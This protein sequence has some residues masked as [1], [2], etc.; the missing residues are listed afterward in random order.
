M[1]HA[2]HIVFLLLLFPAGISAQEYVFKVFTARDGLPTSET[3][4]VAKD[5]KGFLWIGTTSGLSRYDGYTFTNYRYADSNQ[6]ISQVNVIRPQGNKLWVGSDAGLFWI[7]NNRI[8]KVSRAGSLTQGINDILVEDNQLL[9]ATESGPAIIPLNIIDSQHASL[10]VEQYLLPQWNTGTKDS[11]IRTTVIAK[12]SDGAIYIGQERRLFR[13]YNNQL[14]QVNIPPNYNNIILS[15]FPVSHSKV[16]YDGALS[17]LTRIDNGQQSYLPFDSIYQPGNFFEGPGEWQSGTIGVYRFDTATEKISVFINTMDNGVIW[18]SK[19]LKDE[20]FAWLASHNGLLRI[21]PSP[22]KKHTFKTYRNVQEVYSFYELSDGTMLVGANRGKVY[23]KTTDSIRF[24]FEQNKTVVRFAEVFCMYEDERKWLW[25]G[26]GYQGIAVSR[27]GKLYNY[28]EETGLHDNSI[29]QF[30][31]TS[32]G[33]LYAVGDQGLSEIIVDNND[34]IRFKKYNYRPTISQYAKFF[35]AIEGP[36]HTIWIAGQEGLFF[37]KNDSLLPFRLNN[38]LLT[39]NAMTR[40]G[41]GDV[42]IAAAG[43]GVLQCQFTNNGLSIKERYTSNDGLHTSVI[44]ELLA[45][46]N[47]NIWMGSAAGLGVIQRSTGHILNFTHEDGFIPSGYYHMELYQDKQGT[48]WA[49]TTAGITSFNPD[50]LFTPG[51]K[52]VL[53]L[54]GEYGQ[55]EDTDSTGNEAILQNNMQLSWSQNNIQFTL[56]G[57]HFSDQENLDYF[58]RL[59][60]ADTSWFNARQTRNVNYSK[61]NS[62]RY[63]FRAKVLDNK[64]NWSDEAQ[65]S[66]TINAPFWKQLWFLILVLVAATVVAWYIQSLRIKRVREKEKQKLADSEKELQLVSLNRDLVSSQLT[67]LRA[68]M[69]PH[70]IFNALNSVQQYILSG[71]ADQANRYLSKFSRLQR[72]VLNY[73]DQEF[74]KL[75]KEIELLQLYLELEQLRLHENFDFTIALSEDMDSNEINIPPMI[76]QPFI[77]NAIWHGLMPRQGQRSI[78]IHFDLEE[79]LLQCLI[80]DNGIGRAAAAQL[81]QHNGTLPQHTPKGM[82]LVMQRLHILQQQHKQPFEA[83]VTDI[84]AGNDEVTGTQVKLTLFTGRL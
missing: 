59:D 30:L 24:Y 58:Y 23:T 60:G 67:A 72:M 18:P 33:K 14:Q 47:N 10:N 64:G 28:T 29:K 12:A 34:S 27:N 4:C 57:I 37:L 75:D 21:K 49:G 36:D 40:D 63:T 42:W 71:D 5:T 32:N 22:F 25:F 35:N 44:F 26:T 7:N 52:P 15:I 46:R 20:N 19:M 69:N 50:E 9:L 8:T 54:T 73:S 11:E 16:Y 56:T 66:F 61:L 68:Q 77:E 2:S 51:T 17:E 78:N 70:F 82:Q 53:Y 79:N 6:L 31:K 81:K 43:E 84:T 39:I 3:I 65:L 13:Y 48:I 41:N 45:D 83:E 1:R 74:I 55:K 76:I 62:G 38:R 80:R